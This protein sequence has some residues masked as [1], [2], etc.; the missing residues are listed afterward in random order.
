MR[1]VGLTRNFGR[2]EVLHEGVWGTVCDDGFND[3][4]ATVVCRSLGYPMGFGVSVGCNPNVNICDLILGFPSISS[5]QNTVQA[6]HGRIWLDNVQCQGNEVDI[7]ACSHNGWGIHDCRHFEDIGIYCYTPPSAIRLEGGSINEGRVEVMVENMWGTI[8]DEGFTDDSA[9]VVCRMLG[10]QS[11]VAVFGGTFGEGTGFVFMKD[12][13]CTGNER[14]IFS[15]PHDG[16]SCHPCKHSRDV[17]VKCDFV[18][19]SG[20]L[21]HKPDEFSAVCYPNDSI[22]LAGLD[23]GL[24]SFALQNVNGVEVE[25]SIVQTSNTS[26]RI[27]GCQKDESIIF[28][29]SSDS[30]VV[31][32]KVFVDDLLTYNIT[33]SEIPAAGEERNVTQ[34]LDVSIVF[35][36][37]EL[38]KPKYNVTSGLEPATALVG[39]KVVWTIYYPVEYVLEITGCI[40]FPTETSNHSV[41][42]I[43][44]GGCSVTTELVTDF[45]DN[46]NGTVTATINAFKFISSD[47]LYLTCN[48]LICKDE[49]GSCDTR[50]SRPTKGRRNASQDMFPNR[51]FP[52]TVKEV[53]GV[54]E[55][56]SDNITGEV[57]TLFLSLLVVVTS[58]PTRWVCDV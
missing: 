36:N 23:Q 47:T 16:I 27:D 41:P 19:L 44:L 6:G 4:S 14:D 45:I 43:S 2:L 46:G 24:Y 13:T 17:G 37:T 20:I 33:C 7:T 31:A 1:L 8:C 39:D 48:V 54:S 25:C 35:T 21:V 29:L 58:W 55:N 49:H 52:A 5:A 9:S 32:N 40:A 53:L 12:V 30:G 50:C 56:A 42:L 3:V 15:C 26:V 38:F 51:S 34:S 18:S 28:S 11:G 10:F 22:A 57:I